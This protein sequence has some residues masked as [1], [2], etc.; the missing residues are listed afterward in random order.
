MRIH[1][2]T[3]IEDIRLTPSRLRTL[4]TSRREGRKSE[5]PSGKRGAKPVVVA[6]SI[7]KSPYKFL[8]YYRLEDR[9][10]LWPRKREAHPVG[11]CDCRSAGSLVC[12]NGYRQDIAD[13]CRRAAT[14]RG[15]RLCHVLC[16]S[17]RKIRLNQHVEKYSDSVRA[18]SPSQLNTKQ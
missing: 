5:R 9:D 8:D 16:S 2:R 10:I 14:A 4:K 15:S 13:Q 3:R 6:D 18:M 12:S 7:N 1:R 17:K 11:G